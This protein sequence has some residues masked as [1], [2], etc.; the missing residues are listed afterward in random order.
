MKT[1]CLLCAALISSTG[2]SQEANERKAILSFGVGLSLPSQ[3]DEF[4]DYWN[5]GYNLGFGVGYSFTPAISLIGNFEY[6][7]FGFNEEE[8]L[9]DAGASGLGISVDGGSATILSI[10]GNMKV[11]IPRQQSSV[12]PYFTAGIG[13]FSLS[14]DDASVSGAGGSVSVEGNNESAFSALVGAG[15]DI[16]AGETVDVFLQVSYGVGFTE[17]DNTSY[18]PIKAGINLRL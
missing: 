6:N 15:L 1:I 4:S 5:L 11:G 16:P 13:F 2:F 9:K 8:F 10:T 14:V 17:N 3:P 12:S 7:T 18:V